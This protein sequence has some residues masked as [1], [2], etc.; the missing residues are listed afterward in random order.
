MNN[1]DALTPPKLSGSLPLLG[2][3]LDFGKNPHDFMMRLRARL[4]DV[5]EFKMFHQNMVLLTGA[6]AS[7]AFYRAP[8][9]VLDQGPAYKIMTPIFG[10]GVVFDAPI[11]RKNQQL[12]ML[13]PALRDKPM[14]TYSDT[15]VAEVEGLIQNWGES[16]Q[17]DLLEFTKL[18][19]IYTSSHCLLGSEFRHELNEQFA[20]IYH[21][22]EHGIQP[23]AYVFPYLPLP[24]FK[25][26]DR[27]RARLQE[28]VA[29]IMEKRAHSRE[30]STNVF[31]ALIDARY[32]DG[33]KLSAHEITGMLI[34]AVF[35]GHHTSS[36]TTAWV[37]I[38]LL[39]HPEHLQAVQQELE[40]LFGDGNPVTFE[41]LRQMPRLENVIREVLRLHP[42]LIILMRKVVKDFR[43]KN[44]VIKAGQFV[45]AAPS[46][47]HRS[48]ELFPNPEQFD[49]DR[50]APERGED[51]NLY[52][53]QAF[54]GGR[55]KCSGN[56]FALF[57][58]KAI[59]SVLLMRYRFELSAPAE[60]YRDD[61]KKM[62]VEP[63][64][65]CLI[66]YQ[67][68]N[69]AST[70]SSD[71][72]SPGL[73]HQA[74][75]GCPHAA[76]GFQVEIDMDL[77]KGHGACTGEAPEIFHVDEEG[78]VTLLDAQADHALLEKAR[79]AEKYCP[80]QAIRITQTG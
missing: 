25:R 17:L 22:L 11:E 9:D 16:G 77:C 7:E 71:N 49:P 62:V 50:Y 42:P 66:R 61:Y 38:E 46:V 12:Q 6:E 37:L 55:H 30:Q 21:D 54:G 20:E 14:R 35:A 59:I 57:Q 78:R 34:A 24:V 5:A 23:V 26:R 52:G 27:A 33:S 19:T 79:Q 76:A 1:Q 2:H 29:A 44:F 32:D 28:L 74:A 4:G 65:P 40:G 18:L 58:I 72:A 68:N 41:S 15:I 47:T 70:A 31:Q 69:R 80:T 51:R 64:S 8:D 36:G 67:R 73:H 56:A 63:G 48:A 45:C 75:G 39:R 60:S 10:K 43:V 13:M 53:W 3:I